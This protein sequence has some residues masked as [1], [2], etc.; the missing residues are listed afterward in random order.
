[1]GICRLA[2]KAKF[3]VMVGAKCPSSLLVLLVG[4]SASTLLQ[5]PDPCLLA[6]MHCMTDH[7]VSLF[8]AARAH[9]R[10]HQAAVL[11]LSSIKVVVK[12]QQQLDHSLLLY[13]GKHGQHVNNMAVCGDFDTI[14]RLHQQQ[15]Y[16]HAADQIWAGNKAIP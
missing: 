14:H 2:F 12:T 4:Y 5:L 10:L 8:S 6:V 7:H 3:G 16:Q 9:S 11:A 15:T 13:L 1:L